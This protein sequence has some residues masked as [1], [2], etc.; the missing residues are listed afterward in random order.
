LHKSSLTARLAPMWVGVAAHLPYNP[1][2]HGAAMSPDHLI[3]DPVSGAP[4]I[5]AGF[6]VLVSKRQQLRLGHTLETAGYAAPPS[7]AN[8]DPESVV[9]VAVYGSVAG[10][11]ADSSRPP[12][13]VADAGVVPIGVVRVP[14]ATVAAGGGRFAVH[15]EIGLA[16]I[17]CRVVGESG[18]PLEQ[19]WVW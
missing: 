17:D 8:G 2:V 14:A 10:S 7:S 5:R 11:P 16:R 3:T 19:G 1:S 12:L 4:Y 13:R 6:D 18:A 9:L 15:L